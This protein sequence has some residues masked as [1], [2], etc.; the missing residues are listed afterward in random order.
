MHGHER[1]G[2][3]KRDNHYKLHVRLHEIEC[4]NERRVSKL[5]E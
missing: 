4:E 3:D 2:E 1:R 5:A